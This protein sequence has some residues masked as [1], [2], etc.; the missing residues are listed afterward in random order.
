MLWRVFLYLSL[1]II[2]F[3]TFSII[4]FCILHQHYNNHQH[5]LSF[6]QGVIN[7]VDCTTLIL[8]ILTQ[9][10]KTREGKLQVDL[11]LH[12]YHKPRLTKMWTHLECQLG[13]G[14]VGLPGPGETQLEVDKRI[15]QDRILVLKKKIE[16]VQKQQDL[17]R[18]VG[19]RGDCWDIRTRGY[20][21]Y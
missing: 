12:K 19:R 9:H 6:N 13:S 20:Q 16:D 14:G 1:K 17:H 2:F 15:L 8:D 4:I 5:T 7:V 18:G 10:A 3:L 11:T 21:H